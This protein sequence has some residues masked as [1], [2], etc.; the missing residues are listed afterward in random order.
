MYFFSHVLRPL[1]QRISEHQIYTICTSESPD[2]AMKIGGKGRGRNARL[3]MHK[4]CVIVINTRMPWLPTQA[5]HE[6]ILAGQLHTGK[7]NQTCMIRE[8]SGHLRGGP[9]VWVKARGSKGDGQP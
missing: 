5:G 9:F 8:F 4:A 1:F 2:E 3:G 6:W 7:L